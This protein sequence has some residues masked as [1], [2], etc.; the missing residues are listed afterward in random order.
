MTANKKTVLNLSAG[1]FGGAGAFAV[2]FNNLLQA[3]GMASYLLVKEAK[4]KHSQAVVYPNSK[5]DKP[6]GKLM[7]S[8]NK[9][10]LTDNKFVYDYYFYNKYERCTTVSARKVL[11]QIPAK[12]DVIITYWVTD[13]INAQTL[14]ELYELTGAS[15]YCFLVDNAPLTG[16]C[17]YPWGCQGFKQ[18]CAD[19]PAILADN[20]KYVASENL[21]F[22][23][24]YLPE[25]AK[26]VAFSNSDYDRACQSAL[27]RDRD[28]LKLIGFVDETKFTVGNQRSARSYFSLSADKKIIFF[29]ASSLTERRKGMALLQQALSSLQTDSVCLLVAGECTL[30]L[31]GLSVKQAGY[32]SEE[33]LITAYQA[34]DVFVCPSLEDSGP[35]MV[36]QALMCG[37]PVVA[38][39]TGVAQDLVITGK[40]GYRARLGDVADLA[41]GIQS[42]LGLSEEQYGQ[43]AAGCREFAEKTFSKRVV[44]DQLTN[45]I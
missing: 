18:D 8:L 22:K 31:V 27:F 9:Q 10:R 21:A 12:P 37:T 34:A 32:L 29:G 15:I 23:K 26:A 35:M 24:K 42:V 44:M 6:K 30:P 39:D 38:F 1:D 25:S 2:D 19:C 7:R 17:H 33:E 45:V 11:Q 43:M 20:I 13:F 4:N 41:Q 16:G 14:S 40:T 3:S 5:Y 28:V 36:N